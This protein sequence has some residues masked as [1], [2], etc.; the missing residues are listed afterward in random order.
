MKNLENKKELNE[1]EVEMV[2]GGFEP[3]FYS[4][5]PFFNSE[6]EPA[7]PENPEP[8]PLGRQASFEEDQKAALKVHFNF[9]R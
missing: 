4:H 8:G 5:G 2:A 6:P 1:L 7:E 9:G 3:D